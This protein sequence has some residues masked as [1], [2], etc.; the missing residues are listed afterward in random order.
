MNLTGVEAHMQSVVYGV[1]ILIA[2]MV[3]QLKNRT[4]K[5]N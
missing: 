3:D 2:V 4:Q 5:T 1:V